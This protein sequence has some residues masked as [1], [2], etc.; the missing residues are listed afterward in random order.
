MPKLEAEHLELFNHYHLDPSYLNEE[1]LTPGTPAMEEKIADFL[2]KISEGEI[3]TPIPC[4]EPLSAVE[5]YFQSLGVDVKVPSLSIGD[6]KLT[7]DKTE[8]KLSDFDFRSAI[9]EHYPIDSPVVPA[10]MQSVIGQKLVQACIENEIPVIDHRYYHTEE[11]HGAITEEFLGDVFVSAGVRDLDYEF[12]RVCELLDKGATGVCIDITHGASYRVLKLCEMIKD[13]YEDAQVIIGNICHMTDVIRAA[14]AGA[15]AV[16]V[17]MGPGSPCTTRIVTGVGEPQLSSIMMCAIAAE[18]LGLKTIGDGGILDDF[19]AIAA[20]S[21]CNMYGQ[22][23]CRTIES[24][25]GRLPKDIKIENDKIFVK[26][27][28]EASYEAQIRRPGARTAG[29][30]PEG[31]SSWVEVKL[32]LKETVEMINQK[33]ANGLDALGLSSI[34]ELREHVR[35]KGFSE[36]LNFADQNSKN[37]VYEMFRQREIL[38][39]AV[40]NELQD[41]P[42]RELSFNYK[43]DTPNNNVLSEIPALLDSISERGSGLAIEVPGLESSAQAYLEENHDYPTLA[44]LELDDLCLAPNYGESKCSS[45]KNAKVVGKLTE[46]IKLNGA[47]YLPSNIHE[48]PSEH[49]RKQMHENN[50]PIIL[51]KSYS[52]GNQARE[53][54][55]NKNAIPT[56]DA[57]NLNGALQLLTME[58][59]TIVLE[60]DDIESSIQTIELI[61]E[62]YPDVEVII[63]GIENFDEALQVISAGASSII[64]DVEEDGATKLAGVNVAAR[65]FN[66]PVIARAKSITTKQA[67]TAISLGASMVMEGTIS[68]KFDPTR[69][70]N[71][72]EL[73]VPEEL[74]NNLYLTQNASVLSALT[75]QGCTEVDELHIETAERKDIRIVTDAYVEEHHTRTLVI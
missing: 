10:N 68:T 5:L 60:G 29:T 35:E 54:E 4:P 33:L 39:P 11:E 20:G 48:V 30:M 28:G 18:Y 67:H 7:F 47:I 15:D 36:I 58:A 62:N 66:I 46:N 22:L 26:Y 63:S 69:E 61:S 3:T 23:F 42:K 38:N 25:E 13:R 50:Y 27:F 1:G 56:C 57:T 71:E 8:K 17:G 2:Q 32:T 45:R 37:L 24:K 72:E 16:K 41:M 55:R 75:L 31:D 49:A 51:N 74:R 70:F 53:L 59:K 12:E 40:L 73:K 43:G 21:D 9:T 64:V 6:I 34:A 52:V 19:L 14:R 44:A 65:H